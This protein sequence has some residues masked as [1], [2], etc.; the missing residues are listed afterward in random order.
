[1]PGAIILSY[2]CMGP[3]TAR[4]PLRDPPSGQNPLVD[5]PSSAHGRTGNRQHG[6]HV[7]HR[8]CNP[9]AAAAVPTIAPTVLGRRAVVP[10]SAGNGARGG[11]LHDAGTNARVQSDG[12]VQYIEPE[13]DW[14]GPA[15][16]TDRFLRNSLF[17]LPARCRT[18]SRP[19]ISRR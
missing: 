6:D 12:C 15:A 13:L 19:R 18:P 2:A 14:N 10:L 1:M 9:A 11:L 17:L 16:T 4:H 7:Q 8:E 5:G 3:H